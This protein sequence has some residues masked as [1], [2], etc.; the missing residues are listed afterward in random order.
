MFIDG[1]AVNSTS[2]RRS[3]SSFRA[4]ADWDIDMAHLTVGRRVLRCILQTSPS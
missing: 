2:V 4:Q 3:M 1:F